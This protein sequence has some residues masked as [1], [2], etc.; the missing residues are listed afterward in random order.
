MSSDTITGTPFQIP[1]APAVPVEDFAPSTKSCLSLAFMFGSAGH[2]RPLAQ[3]ITPA[4]A[5]GGSKMAENPTQEMLQEHVAVLKPWN[6]RRF[7]T[8]IN[9]ASSSPNGAGFRLYSLAT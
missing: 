7:M 4:I 6:W 2:S 8:L 1:A 9:A 5:P 3:K